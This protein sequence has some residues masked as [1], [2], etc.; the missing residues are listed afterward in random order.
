MYKSAQSQVGFTKM[1]ALYRLNIILERMQK[2]VHPSLNAE[3]IGG[4][5]AKYQA[6]YYALV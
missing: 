6:Y 2:C 5:F 1:V 4:K 3:P